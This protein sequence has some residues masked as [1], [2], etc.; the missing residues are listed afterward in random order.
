[1]KLVFA[2]TVHIANKDNLKG[3]RGTTEEI[4]HLS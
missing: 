3:K 1:M 4:K 2:V